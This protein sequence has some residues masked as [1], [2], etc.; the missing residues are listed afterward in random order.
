MEGVKQQGNTAALHAFVQYP[1]DL[2]EG[3][4]KGQQERMLKHAVRF[5]NGF[6]GNDAFSR[7]GSTATRPP[8][9]QSIHPPPS[10]VSPS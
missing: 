7:R 9:P 8:P 1:I 6:H 3:T 2:I 5:M 10:T 4:A